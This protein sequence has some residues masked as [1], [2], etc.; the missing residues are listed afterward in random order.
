MFGLCNSLLATLW[1][2]SLSSFDVVL[3]DFRLLCWTV[4]ACVWLVWTPDGSTR[5][6]SWRCLT[7]RLPNNCSHYHWLY[8][9][10][11]PFNLSNASL[12][13][14][15]VIL[16]QRVMVIALDDTPLKGCALLIPTL[17][18]FGPFVWTSLQTPLCKQIV[19][20]RRVWSPDKLKLFALNNFR[21]KQ[22]TSCLND[23]S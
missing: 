16:C 6:H 7:L 2:Y 22:S 5:F 11:R 12:V 23:K 13:F 14:A 20:F 4:L 19:L 1:I 17:E 21:V 18:Q 8:Q 3:L 10:I 15:C 9:L